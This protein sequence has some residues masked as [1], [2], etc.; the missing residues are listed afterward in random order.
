MA[1]KVMDGAKG[2][3]LLVSLLS[4][5]F[6]CVLCSRGSILRLETFRQ[7]DKEPT[8]VKGLDLERYVGRWYEIASTPS[9]F[10]PENGTDTRATYALNKN[11]TVDVLN[12]SWINGKRN[13][14]KGF[15][16]KDDPRSDEAKFEMKFYVPLA[17]SIFPAVGYY[18][19]LY[20]DADYQYSIVGEP[21]R[22]YLFILSRKSHV[23]DETYKQLVQ[24]AVDE[25]YDVS[26][27][28]KI[29]QSDTPPQ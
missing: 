8:V 11:G 26:N 28:L 19:V 9:F 22:H 5:M 15:A 29:P 18:W 17:F 24:K 14:I 13:F 25:G 4:S 20:L 27:L 21:G 3:F 12:E 10:Q 6:A 2:L 16:Y 23:D 1:K 7:P